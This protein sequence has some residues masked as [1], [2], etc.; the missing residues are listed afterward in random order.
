M[1]L[2]HTNLTS[3]ICGRLFSTATMT[4]GYVKLARNLVNKYAPATRRL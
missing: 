2:I 4:V 3:G 1:S